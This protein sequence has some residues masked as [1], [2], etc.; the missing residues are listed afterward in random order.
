MPEKK[1]AV[2]SFL[3]K[4]SYLD[5][6]IENY[7]AI[8]TPLQQLT[9]REAEFHWGKQ[10]DAFRK[11]KDSISNEKTM[12]F[13]D[14]GKTIILRTEATFNEGLSGA[15]RFRIVTGHKPLFNKVKAKVPRRIEK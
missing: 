10:E 2:R 14:P 9:R 3:G 5:N 1:E 8:V 15:S 12:A 6:F 4:A 7:A 13:F 11:I